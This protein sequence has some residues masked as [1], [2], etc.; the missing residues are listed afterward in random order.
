MFAVGSHFAVR[1]SLTF[2]VLIGILRIDQKVRTDKWSV[3]IRSIRDEG[4][5]GVKYTGGGWSRCMRN[6]CQ[7][8]VIVLT[9]TRSQ[10]PSH[11]RPT[12]TPQT[13]KEPA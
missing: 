11:H 8:I 5:M 4:L 9:P 12:T 2:F 3:S 1:I 13:R 6:E 7:I 10:P